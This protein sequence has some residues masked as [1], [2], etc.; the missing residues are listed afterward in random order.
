MTWTQPVCD[1]CFA[2]VLPQVPNPVRLKGEMR[3]MERC[4]L[5]GISTRS[6]LYVRL[7]PKDVPH[8]KEGE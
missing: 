1:T 2:G 4:C 5:C 8:P 7:N 6:G 3:E